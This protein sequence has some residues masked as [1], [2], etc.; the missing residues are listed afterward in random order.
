[1]GRPGSFQEPTGPP[2]PLP[3]LDRS[4]YHPPAQNATPS[5]HPATKGESAKGKYV[6]V[7]GHRGTCSVQHARAWHGIDGRLDGGWRHMDGGGARRVSLFFFF[8]FLFKL[9]RGNRVKTIFA[10]CAHFCALLLQLRTNIPTAVVVAGRKSFA[11]GY[12]SEFQ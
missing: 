2:P 7:F 9:Y 1:M 4:A 12:I 11:P 5:R 10:P 8:F 3:P 6:L